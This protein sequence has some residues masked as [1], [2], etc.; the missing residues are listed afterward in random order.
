MVK[1]KIVTNTSKSLRNASVHTFTDE[2][3]LYHFS[4][5]GTELC[6]G[7]EQC[8]PSAETADNCKDEE[9]V[10]GRKLVF[11]MR[12]RA[13]ARKGRMT[14]GFKGGSKAKETGMLHFS[15][16]AEIMPTGPSY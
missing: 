11:V 15:G 14:P 3:N 10:R 5:S 12:A 2:R 16:H 9:K 13:G 8:W 6:D 1:S 4:I 7:G